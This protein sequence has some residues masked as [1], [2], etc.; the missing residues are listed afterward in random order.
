MPQPSAQVTA[1][2]ISRIAGVTRATVSNWRRRHSD[3]PAPAGGTE[4]SPLYDL[5]AVRVWLRSRGQTSAAAPAEELRTLLRLHPSAPAAPLLP[6][7]LA[8]SRRSPHELTALT[9]LPDADLAARAD[10]AVAGLAGTVPQAEAA[11]FTAADA[12]V[13]RA[14]IHCVREEGAQA[15]LDVLAERELE[16]SASTGTYRTPTPLADPMA[17]L[18]PAATA[19]VLDPACG[20]RH[21][22]EERGRAM[23]GRERRKAGPPRR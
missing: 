6:L 16:D 20:D 8:T 3:F 2:E 14:L 1:A 21:P 22:G 4:A 7:V 12:A 10:A 19:R 9:D 5:E 23:E 11:P 17:R 18:L 13:V 15:A